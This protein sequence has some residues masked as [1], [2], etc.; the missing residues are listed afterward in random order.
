MLTVHSL[1]KSFN[2]QI[3]FDQVTFSLNPGD[4]LGLVGPNGCGKTTLLRILANR[5]LPTAG[6]VTST[7]HQGIG[8]LVQGFEYNATDTVGEIVARASGNVN[9]LEADLANNAEALMLLPD[10]ISL[11]AHYDDL[12][13]HVEAAETGQSLEIFDGAVLAIVHDRY[14]IE[15]FAQQIWWIEGDK[16]A[17]R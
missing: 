6:S 3:L 13:R 12:L 9:G 14:F 17:I 16:I 15:R 10:N 11:Q 5:E 7:S 8:Y 4:R 2:L 1:K